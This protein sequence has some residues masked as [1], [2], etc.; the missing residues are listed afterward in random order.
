MLKVIAAATE[1]LRKQLPRDQ[2]DGQSVAQQGGKHRQHK[3]EASAGRAPFIPEK[4]R[5]PSYAKKHR[6]TDK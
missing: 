6:G 1:Q 3:A 4:K 5:H 2:K